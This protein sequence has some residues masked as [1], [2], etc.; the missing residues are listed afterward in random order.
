MLDLGKYRPRSKYVSLKDFVGKSIYIIKISPYVNKRFNKPGFEIVANDDNGNDLIFHTIASTVVD[1][2][3]DLMLKSNNGEFEKPIRTT[4]ESI[5]IGMNNF[6]K[7][8]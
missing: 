8:S 7:L 6:L 3:N 2:L 1:E 5:Q 4:V